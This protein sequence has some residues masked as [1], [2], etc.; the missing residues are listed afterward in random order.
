MIRLWGFSVARTVTNPTNEAV[1]MSAAS[2]YPYG[3]V[4]DLASRRRKAQHN[5][6]PE[7]RESAF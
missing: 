4:W 2:N 7:R 1:A 5:A 6:V 3:T